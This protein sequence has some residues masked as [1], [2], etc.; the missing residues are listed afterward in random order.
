VLH[1]GS[2]TPTV[3]LDIRGRI[4][5]GGEQGLLGLAFHQD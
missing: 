2:S 4:A 5:S 3:F 1:P